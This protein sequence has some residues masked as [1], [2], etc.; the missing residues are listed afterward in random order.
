M[1]VGVPKE[2]KDRE[3]RVALTPG[4]ARSLVESGHQVRVEAGAGEGSGFLDREYEKVGA[5]LVSAP[6][7]WDCG[8]VLKVKEPLTSEYGYLAGQILFTYLHL[9]GVRRELTEALLAAGTTA[10]GYE[11]VEDEVGRLPLLAPM[12]AV[13]GNMAVTVGAHCLGRPQGGRG[14]LLGN[15]LGESYGKVTIVGDGV[16]GRHAAHVADGMGARVFLF[17]LRPE[18]EAD[19]KAAISERLVFVPSNAENLAAHCRDA[20]LLIG[21][22]LR[23]GARAPL[24][25]S[26][27]MVRTMPS[28][29][30][31]VDV[32][33]DQGGCVATS[34]PTSHSHPVVV[35]HGVSHYGVTNMPGAYPRTSTL[36][37]TTATLPYVMEVAG[38]G[39]AALSADPGLA[40]G[41]NTHAGYITHP[42][43]AEALGLEDRY[44]AF[45]EVSST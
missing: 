12:S 40:K 42:A 3:D 6:A 41:V 20:D 36:A 21:A 2:L 39:R 4:G 22:V 45:A 27:E 23:R 43:V 30:V 19:L 28:G 15:V 8:L 38:Q 26:E 17:G 7:A 9:S 13:A 10:L 25:V 1:W 31:V 44:R 29:A 16:V 18:R 5:E 32:S 24:V 33:I 14:M 34:E 11:T 37:L 35:R